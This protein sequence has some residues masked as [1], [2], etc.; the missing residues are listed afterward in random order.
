MMQRV[1]RIGHA[2][3]VAVRI[4]RAINVAGGI[5]HAIDIDIIQLLT[6]LGVRTVWWRL[7]PTMK[8]TCRRYHRQ[9]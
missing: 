4:R 9:I 5:W 1:G 6:Q 3:A 8:P 7:G 2:I